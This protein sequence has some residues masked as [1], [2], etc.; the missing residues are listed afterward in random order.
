MQ[1]PLEKARNAPAANSRPEGLECPWPWQIQGCHP[2]IR[3]N[4][5]RPELAALCNI[6]FMKNSAAPVVPENA[7]NSFP[8]PSRL[9]PCLIYDIPGLFTVGIRLCLSSLTRE[10][11]KGEEF[12]AGPILTG[13]I[14][15]NPELFLLESCAGV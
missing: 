3:V 7:A 13:Q 5:T 2:R 14:L 9:R 11:S 1:T 10:G 8:L 12:P 4:R 15:L 6:L